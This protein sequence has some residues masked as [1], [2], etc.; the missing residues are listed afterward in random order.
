MT[1]PSGI[2][3]D[4]KLWVI[5]EGGQWPDFLE[6]IGKITIEPRGPSGSKENLERVMSFHKA[7]VNV[8]KEHYRKAVATLKARHMVGEDE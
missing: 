6:A 7:W 3:I 1:E 5:I 4:R 2:R 8:K